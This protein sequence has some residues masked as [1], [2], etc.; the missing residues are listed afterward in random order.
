METC[1]T[2]GLEMWR[3]G[4]RAAPGRVATDRAS[5]SGKEIRRQRDKPVKSFF[6]FN[7]ST[8]TML[9]LEK[10]ESS[11]AIHNLAETPVVDILTPYSA[12]VCLTC[13]YKL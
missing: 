12:S 7:H 1:E 11:F 6:N 9:D 13:R 10:S 8:T 2:C 4:C 5:E 3:L